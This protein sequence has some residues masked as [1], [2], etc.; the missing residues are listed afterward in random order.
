MA[1]RITVAI[2]KEAH[3]MLV[4]LIEIEDHPSYMVMTLGKEIEFLIS[5]RLSMLERADKIGDLEKD[6]L[7]VGRKKD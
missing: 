4:K 2:T 6:I 5:Q 7:T 3:E 1:E